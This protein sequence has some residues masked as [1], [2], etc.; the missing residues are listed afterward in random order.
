VNG[1]LVTMWWPK[2]L[3]CIS[4]RPKYWTKKWTKL[5]IPARTSTTTTT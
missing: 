5:T 4:S 1:L 2:T 3:F